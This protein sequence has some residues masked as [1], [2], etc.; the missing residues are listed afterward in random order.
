MSSSRLPG[1]AL[2]PL[3]GYPS[4]VL[5]ALRAGREGTPVIVATSTETS[6]DILTE[7]V[8]RAGLRVV[9]GPLDDVL[10]RFVRATADMA[11]D[12]I[13]VRL[14]A[15]NVVPDAAFIGRVVS[16]LAESGCDYVGTASP[17]NGMP[18]GLS[19]EAFRVRVLRAADRKAIIEHDRSD[20]T[21]WI[22]RN[23]RAEIYS[24][25]ICNGLGAHIR[26]TI[27]S[28]DDYQTLAWAM[29][30]VPDPTG[31]DSSEILKQ[32]AAAPGAPS[33]RIPFRVDGERTLGRL[34]LGTVQFGLDYGRLN[35]A[36]RPRRAE[37]CEMIRT[38][39]RHGVTDIDSARCYGD[40]EEIIGE[41][42]RD[43]WRSRVRL[44]TKIDLPIKRTIDSAAAAAMVDA[45]AF[46]S[47]RAL[48]T[49]TLDVVMVREIWPLREA[50]A[51][52]DRLLQLRDNG[53]IGVLGLSAQSPEETLLGLAIPEIGH[54]QLPCNILDYRWNDAQVPQAV[55]RR[56]DCVIHARSVYLQGLLAAGGPDQWP[57][58]DDLNPAEIITCL[59]MLAQENGF[60][61]R[62]ALCLAYARSCDWID[63]IVL[64]M[65]S[66][67]Q[68]ATN[69]ALFNE[70]PLDPVH[71]AKLASSL[72]RVP[73]ALLNPSKWIS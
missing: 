9:R 72:P 37:A 10:K 17:Q 43:G 57:L 41:A 2:L 46:A 1:K 38:A 8:A 47:L 68:L 23:C 52:W 65:D 27:D 32:L 13:A 24:E 61:N 54:I 3:A 70:T 20:V 59:D 58:I 22:I 5:A 71:A 21:P 53:I 33:F 26:C 66:A 4:V 14:T 39:V 18:Y 12:D 49:D 50:N 28:L 35:A 19:A 42:L 44:L 15:D 45:Q 63:G 7:I 62:A 29:A 73:H 55:R 69:L 67:Q 30:R 34:V 64:G 36:G 48:R 25:P 40:A 56:P 16:R 60:A 11:D 51:F 6:D 31:C